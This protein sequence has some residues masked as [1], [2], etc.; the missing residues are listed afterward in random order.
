METYFVNGHYSHRHDANIS[1]EDRGF[2]FA[3]GVYEVIAFTHGK[4]LNFE[5]HIKRLER[6]LNEIRIK[7]PYDNLKSLEI[8]FKQLIKKNKI[9]NGFLYLQITRGSATRKHEFPKKITPNV[10]IFCFNTKNH[11][12]L[13]KGV[14]VGLSDDLRWKRCDIKSISLLP[15]LLEKQ[16]ASENGLYEIWQIRENFIT[17]GSTSNA[18][19]IN[20]EDTI[21]THPANKFILGGVTRDCVIEIAKKQGFKFLEKSFSK[22]DLRSCNEAFLSSTTVGIL[23]VIQVDNIII[24]DGKPGKNTIELMKN[25]QKF[26]SNQINK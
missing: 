17:E 13:N 12:L 8:I 21:L 19:I 6:S 11:E 4:I 22:N 20:S 3:D 5:R 14:K 15:N 16:K 1:V 26:L 9:L 10:V 23:P 18:F 25:Y 2:N 7:N 24:K